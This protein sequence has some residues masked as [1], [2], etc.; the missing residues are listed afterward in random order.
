[1]QPF[2]PSTASTT[3]TAATA[4]PNGKNLPRSYSRTSPANQ[5]PK[6][7]SQENSTLDAEPLTPESSSSAYNRARSLILSINA[8][9]DREELSDLPDFSRSFSTRMLWNDW[10]KLRGEFE[11]R[12]FAAPFLHCCSDAY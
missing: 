11:F 9:F 5:V 2:L 12:R 3:V 8:W 4:R 7:T 6:M 10:A 1:M